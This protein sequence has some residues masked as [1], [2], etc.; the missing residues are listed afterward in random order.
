MTL[1]TKILDAARDE[2][3][4]TQ[5]NESTGKPYE[6]FAQY[7]DDMRIGGEDGALYCLEANAALLAM[8]KQAEFY[9]W[10]SKEHQWSDEHGKFSN[11]FEFKD[12]KTELELYNIWREGK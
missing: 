7:N 12:L 8:E 4:N 1:H 3:A 11:I 2:V 10:V 9:K 5:I 6:S